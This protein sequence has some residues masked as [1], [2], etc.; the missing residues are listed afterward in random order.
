MI[1]SMKTKIFKRAVYG[2]AEWNYEETRG[3]I[4]LQLLVVYPTTV[5][6]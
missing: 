4:N 6:I 3:M 2:L 1:L 5:F